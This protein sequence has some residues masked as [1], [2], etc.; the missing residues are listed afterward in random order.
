M[1]T[2]KYKMLTY[3]C[4]AAVAV[5]AM[6]GF[7]V[8]Y[9]LEQSITNQ[10]EMLIS[11]IISQTQGILQGHNMI[12]QSYVDNIKENVR[13]NTND[14]TGSRIAVIS[15]RNHLYN[16]L[17]KLLRSSCISSGTDF[18]VVYDIEGKLIASYPENIDKNSVEN[19]FESWNPD[20]IVQKFSKKSEEESSTLNSV[21]KHD[22]E[23]LRAF[24]LGER[25]VA[26]KGGISMASAGVVSDDYGIPVGICISGRLLNGFAKPLEQ[27][28][29]ATG[30]SSLFYLDTVPLAQAGFENT[31][32][33]LKITASQMSK[34]Y[35]SENV[36]NTVIPLAGKNYIS[37]SSAIKSSDGKKIGIVC[38]AYPEDKIQ[39][40]RS[41]LSS[42]IATRNT[43]YIWLIVAGIISL[44]VFAI[45][46]LLIATKTT[47]LIAHV[48]TGLSEASG[49]IASASG[50]L[51]SISQHVATGTGEQASSVEQT[52][53]FLEEMSCRARRNAEN[54][55]KVG[56]SGGEAYNTLQTA[57][58]AMKQTLGA[59]DEIRSG[60]EKTGK[61]I[62]TIDDIAF[63][64]NLLSLNAA[65]E[66]AHAGDAGA[67]FAVVADEVRRLAMRTAEAAKN[68][69]LLIENIIVR[70]DAGAGLLEKTHDSF[71]TA[72]GQHE[73][74]K[75]LISEIISTSQ[76]QAYDVEQ[77][78]MTMA[79]VDR[80]TQ[81]TAAN[82][83]R[84]AFTSEEMIGQSDQLK[85]F[86]K[87][88][89]ALV[90]KN[91]HHKTVSARITDN[92]TGFPF[93]ATDSNMKFLSH[94]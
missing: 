82:A 25:D 3:F 45:V 64:T 10:E 13:T 79:Q 16:T 46:A 52:T 31:E 27:I 18:A 30:S 72:I 29:N 84:T 34:V 39:V 93:L 60:G 88:L 5:I 92:R 43:L 55:N 81:Q 1:K 32:S 90:G 23:F 54:A 83:E 73:E 94:S 36:F 53:A 76:E 80:V 68:T 9:K 37:S 71:N 24:G 49:N 41:L 11:D 19:Y 8:S 35:Q 51:A 50:E 38:V 87:D 33:D 20:S 69:S 12:L 91:G 75:R 70:I 14:M 57:N 62:R 44:I 15:I 77:I 7:I 61:I 40:R 63:Q 59:M 56:F 89:A 21:L 26:G 86:V 65:V 22:S 85:Q 4:L 66:A 58:N 6:I 17:G 42:S 47:R 48:I 78:N 2:I 67:G 28:Y 74:M